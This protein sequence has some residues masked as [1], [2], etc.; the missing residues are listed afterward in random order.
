MSTRNKLK[1][2]ETK[3]KLNEIKLDLNINTNLKF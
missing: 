1:K 3:S 2:T